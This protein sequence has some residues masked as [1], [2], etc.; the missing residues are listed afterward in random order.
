[1]QLGTIKW[2]G[3]PAGSFRALVPAYHITERHIADVTMLFNA[4]MQKSIQPL[5]RLFAAKE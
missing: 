2:Q 4:Y 3:Y 5:Q 1:V